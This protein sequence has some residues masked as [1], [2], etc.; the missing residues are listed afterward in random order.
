M[1]KKLHFENWWKCPCIY[2]FN[3][4]LVLIRLSIIWSSWCWWIKIYH[5]YLLN[6]IKKI[7]KK[8]DWTYFWT[9]NFFRTKHFCWPKFLSDLKKNLPKTF[10]GTKQIY[11]GMKDI[12][13]LKKK[14]YQK[15]LCTKDFF[16]Q[17]FFRAKNLLDKH[18]FSDQH[19]FFIEKF[20]GPN[21]FL[22]ESFIGTNNFFWNFCFEPNIFSDQNFFSN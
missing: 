6:W 13:W 18:F 16:W 17:K 4:H 11:F 3:W 20:L 1:G 9:K 15:S 5:L 14:I 8:S 22:T 19:F 10:V 12:F 7:K 21:F 2:H